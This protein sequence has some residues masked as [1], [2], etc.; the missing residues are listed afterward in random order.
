MN[1]L[2]APHAAEREV[3]TP[4]STQLAACRGGPL[5]KPVSIWLASRVD[6]GGRSKFRAP[7]PETASL[8][9]I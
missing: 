3:G 2:N 5:G 8:G 7:P 6:R 4:A 9:L 1:R